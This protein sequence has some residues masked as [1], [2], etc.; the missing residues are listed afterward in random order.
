MLVLFNKPYDVLCQFTGEPDR[1]TL[2]DYIPIKNIYAAGRLDRDSEGL[3][4]LTD[5]G[6]L[7]D[8]IASPAHKLKKIYWAQVEG[9][10]NHQ[11]IS[12]LRQGVTLKDGVTAPAEARCI[13]EPAVWPRTPPIRARKLLPASWLELGISEGRNRQVRRMTA[14]LG[15]PTLRL[16]R[17]AIGPW[18]LG[19]LQPG[20]YRQL[21]DAQVLAALSHWPD[22][23]DLHDPRDLLQTASQPA[24]P[25]RS[26]ASRPQPKRPR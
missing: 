15:F 8:F 7:Q 12:Q 9:E 10:I 22:L 6:R 23:H 5:H 3:L 24:I 26:R 17:V 14:A 13:D 19:D 2:A 18:H 21:A 4:L 25:K 11:A 20:Q 1:K 16:I